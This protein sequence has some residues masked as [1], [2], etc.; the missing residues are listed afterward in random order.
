MLAGWRKWTTVMALHNPFIG[1]DLGNTRDNTQTRLKNLEHFKSYCLEKLTEKPTNR[2]AIWSGVDVEVD[3][4]PTLG[5][6][7]MPFK[8]WIIN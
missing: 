1:V 7:L 2:S 4:K 6:E 5:E 8:Q 3:A